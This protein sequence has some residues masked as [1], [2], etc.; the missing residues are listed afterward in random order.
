MPTIQ[1]SLKKQIVPYLDNGFGIID[2]STKEIFITSDELKKFI[3]D[4]KNRKSGFEILPFLKLT[5]L[6]LILKKRNEKYDN[7]VGRR[8]AQFIYYEIKNENKYEFRCNFID[9]FKTLHSD[10]HDALEYYNNDTFLNFSNELVRTF[11]FFIRYPFMINLIKQNK[12]F[13]IKTWN[14]INYGFIFDFNIIS[15]HLGLNSIILSNNNLLLYYHKINSCQKTNFNNISNKQLNKIYFELNEN[16]YN[17]ILN[18]NILEIESSLPK[19]VITLEN[20]KFVKKNYFHDRNS[21]IIDYSEINN[22]LKY[23]TDSLLELIDDWYNIVFTGGALFNALNNLPNQDLEIISQ[24]DLDFFFFGNIEDQ[25]RN[26]INIIKK[27][28]EKYNNAS[29]YYIQNTRIIEIWIPNKRKMQFIFSLQNAGSPEDIINNFDLGCFKCYYNG[30]SIFLS[31][32]C[33]YSLKYGFYLH[34][35][36]WAWNTISGYMT[37][38]AQTKIKR[39]KKTMKKGLPFSDLSE[40]YL[41]VICKNAMG[42]NT[43]KFE[44][45]LIEIDLEKTKNDALFDNLNCLNYNSWDSDLEDEVTIFNYENSNSNQNNTTLNWDDILDSDSDDEMKPH[46]FSYGVSIKKKKNDSSDDS[47]DE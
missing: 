3:D 28:K 39:T 4:K 10:M 12:Q 35:G 13:I 47:S 5:E 15:F 1:Y 44:K 6:D 21:Y 19:Q 11:K 43:Y 24:S 7:K 14:P 29:V 31:I 30:K 26:A 36:M 40:H 2:K 18:I 8:L 23:H 32:S 42:K 9:V 38:S 27:A 41:S 20:D 45:N 16:I 46:A 22:K 37:H 25:K 34:D 33:I 17:N